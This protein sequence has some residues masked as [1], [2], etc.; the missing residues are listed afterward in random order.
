ML[1][2]SDLIKRLRSSYDNIYRCTGYFSDSILKKSIKAA[3]SY[4][5]E[6]EKSGNG[7]ISLIAPDIIIEPCMIAMKHNSVRF[8]QATSLFIE[9][10]FRDYV[11]PTNNL[12]SEE[13]LYIIYKSIINIETFRDN[14]NLSS[15]STVLN[16]LLSEFVCSKLA[17]TSDLYNL[18]NFLVTLFFNSAGLNQR[19]RITEEA[20][21]IFD[22][23]TDFA[24]KTNKKFEGETS[25]ISAWFS[26]KKIH[27]KLLR[28]FRSSNN[29]NVSTFDINMMILLLPFAKTVYNDD[30][31]IYTI[32]F[33]QVFLVKALK[34]KRELI[35][36]I[37][38][39][40]ILRSYYLLS[41]WRS[42]RINRE[43]VVVK[44]A[45]MLNLIWANCGDIATSALRYII[46]KV[47]IEGLRAGYKK[48]IYMCW[49]SILEND[50]LFPEIFSFEF[51]SNQKGNVF[52]DL[53]TAIVNDFD[54]T[55]LET[56]DIII[57][58]TIFGSLPMDNDKYFYQD[59]YYKNLDPNDA[60]QELLNSSE[61][62]KVIRNLSKK[63][64]VHEK[65]LI[66]VTK[67]L[68][69]DNVDPLVK[70]VLFY[71]Y[72]F[73]LISIYVHSFSFENKS[74]F[75]AFKELFSTVYLPQNQ[76]TID[77]FIVCFAEHYCHCNKEF[78]KSTYSIYNLA[79]NC[80]TLHNDFFNEFYSSEIIE[81]KFIDINKRNR[82]EMTLSDDELKDLYK[83]LTQHKFFYTSVIK[84]FIS[85]DQMRE[86]YFTVLN[87]FSYLPQNIKYILISPIYERLSKFLSDIILSVGTAYQARIKVLASEILSEVYVIAS[88][89]FDEEKV[90]EFKVFYFK[91]MQVYHNYKQ[92]DYVEMTTTFI[93]G[94]MRGNLIYII[95]IAETI[96]YNISV[97]LED[98]NIYPSVIDTIFE[99][100]DSL[101]ER[102]INQF[103]EGFLIACKTELLQKRFKLYLKLID[104]A[105]YNLVR[106]VY[107]WRQIWNL[108][109]KFLTDVFIMRDPSI[110]SVTIDI[111]K[112]IVVHVFSVK[113]NDMFRYQQE[114]MLPFL[115]I[116]ET[117]TEP[118]DKQMIFICVEFIIQR[119]GKVL[120]SGWDVVIQLLTDLAVEQFDNETLIKI[121][122]LSLVY[123][124]DYVVRFSSMLSL[125]IT[126]CSNDDYCRK[127]LDILL[128]L[129]NHIEKDNCN[130]WIALF[131]NIQGC[132]SMNNPDIAKKAIK[133][134]LDMSKNAN[135]SAKVFLWSNIMSDLNYK[136][137]EE[138]FGYIFNTFKHSKENY[139]YVYPF[140][141]NYINDFT[142]VQKLVIDITTANKDFLLA[143]SKILEDTIAKLR[144]KTQDQRLFK[145]MCV[146][147]KEKIGNQT[148]LN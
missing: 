133:L 70:G 64:E 51:N 80:F 48:S 101:N 112:Q 54:L 123:M 7:D 26:G 56:I 141:L 41:L 145:Q 89:N 96:L 121:C 71:R 146:T 30:Y 53:V 47:F 73:D 36:T 25:D 23:F 144:D 90:E 78:M 93:S 2:I 104:I 39:L 98:F 46:V 59:P 35:S 67:L 69:G 118:T 52:A 9:N 31:D 44:S 85:V 136:F 114:I 107:V 79:F 125:F 8:F 120:Y 18:F 13:S 66:S 142:D 84:P 6:F 140:L 100:I 111:L 62:K 49:K 92:K 1:S 33:C 103:I 4:L 3:I 99:N 57:L 122:E 131:Q 10:F 130:T 124:K 19:V 58:N 143:N 42:V 147:L 77:N 76:Q 81:D 24:T 109:V 75:D 12:P 128:L 55:R 22:K 11:V 110:Y 139:E 38:F 117:L 43:S 88:K 40:K 132:I 16:I 5:D 61:I 137:A 113:Q 63:E 68:K 20:H 106:P 94:F 34:I 119:Y 102:Q 129:S 28:V 45:E 105:R 127:A 21:G 50:D 82:D 116:Y 115:S 37:S 95:D 148:H 126:T 15:V 72:G 134:I 97:I 138:D 17:L 27:K 29:E 74:F 108:V 83:N 14:S 87:K 65:S 86:S 60:N 32:E 135:S 91:F